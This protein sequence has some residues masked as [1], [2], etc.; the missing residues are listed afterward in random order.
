M[1]S[2][3]SSSLCCPSSK[4]ARTVTALVVTDAAA[5]DFRPQAIKLR[6]KKKR[7]AFSSKKQV[8]ATFY[9]GVNSIGLLCLKVAIIYI[10]SQP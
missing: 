3:S 5:D 8:K 1:L 2:I 10:I 7:I 6:K 9:F 4:H